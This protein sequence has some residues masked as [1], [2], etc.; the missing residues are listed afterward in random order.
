M[1][2]ISRKINWKITR[3]NKKKQEQT[4]FFEYGKDLKI[5]KFHGGFYAFGN[6][7]LCISLI[8]V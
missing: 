6:F 4:I 1:L 7:T 5:A 8:Q 3:N 2:R